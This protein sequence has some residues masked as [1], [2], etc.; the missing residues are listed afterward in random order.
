M[1]KSKT[2][3]KIVSMVLTTALV[4]GIMGAGK[5]P[6]YDLPSEAELNAAGARL[7]EFIDKHVDDPDFHALFAEFMEQNNI[8]ADDESAGIRSSG[9]RYWL[10][11][12]VSG[13]SNFTKSNFWNWEVWGFGQEVAVMQMEFQKRNWP[14]SD[15][16]RTHNSGAFTR[17]REAIVYSANGQTANNLNVNGDPVGRALTPWV[18]LSSNYTAL[19]ASTTIVP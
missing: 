11:E 7:L 2:I 5:A 10:L 19:S 9:T 16:V 15:R 4:F 18:N 12:E 6:V 17:Y 3:K 8:F 14:L 13:S 1:T